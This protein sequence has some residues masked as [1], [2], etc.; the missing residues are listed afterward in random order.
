MIAVFLVLVGGIAWGWMAL[1][2]K[3]PVAK[4]LGK[5]AWIVYGLVGISA[6]VLMFIGRNVFLPFLG[7]TVFP[8]AA[9]EER[10]PEG[11]NTSVQVQVKPGAK[12]LY[13]AAEPAMD[14]LKTLHNWKEAYGSYKNV[15]V[16][17]AD[18]SGMAVLRVRNPQSYT[19]PTRT[20]APHIHY[21]ICMKDG[22]M[23]QVETTFLATETFEVP[24]KPVEPVVPVIAATP[25]LPVIADPVSGLPTAVPADVLEGF[26]SEPFYSAVT[27]ESA[28]M[29][30]YV[31]EDPRLLRLHSVVE[32]DAL[33][34]N[35][36]MAY[37]GD[38]FGTALD[39][40]FQSATAPA[41]SK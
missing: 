6:I 22:W 17:T 39:A 37:A 9:L 12:V 16:T 36:D 3:N 26:S 13:W 38:S 5:R 10:E 1:S 2:G 35:D 29:G 21:R 30:S 33:K 20:L 14:G 34:V 15:G 7:P 19:V 41:P 40:A 18:D 8:C 25:E 31:Q 11:A 24:V 27:E 32:A 23:S 28:P 4:M